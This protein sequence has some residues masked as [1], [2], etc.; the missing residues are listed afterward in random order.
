MASASCPSNSQYEALVSAQV[1]GE[2]LIPV[3]QGPPP[4]YS[5]SDVEDP[6]NDHG[7][8]EGGDY[9][10]GVYDA[11]GADE[12]FKDD[13]EA[14][15]QGLDKPYRLA[16]ETPPDHPAYHLSFAKV[17]SICEDLFA[18]AA[19]LLENSDYQDTYTQEL[20]SKIKQRQAIAHDA[21]K[22]IGLLGDSGVGTMPLQLVDVVGSNSI[23]GSTGGACTCVITEYTQAPQTQVPAF[24]ADIE[25]FSMAVIEKILKEH[26][27]AYYE[28]HCDRSVELKGDELEAAEMDATT[29][30]DAFK[31]LFA[32]RAEFRDKE[33]ATKFLSATTSSSDSKMLFKLLSWVKD[34]IS[35][36]GCKDGSIHRSSEFSDNF[37]EHI[38]QFVAM[39]PIL[40]DENGDPLEPTPSFYPIV[41]IVRV[42]LQSV[43]LS[44]GIVIADLPGLS[45]T[46]RMR[47]KMTQQYIRRCAYYVLVAPI[48]RVTTDNM[49]HHRLMQAFL[50]PGSHK[51]L[52]C[53][54]IDHEALIIM[55]NQK[56][57]L[58]IRNKYKDLTPE[59]RKLRVV[60]VS[61]PHYE[62]H[63]EG[64][65]R[66]ALPISIETTG[67]PALR[68]ELSELPAQAKL[69]ALL[70]RV[71]SGLRSTISSLTNY[72]TQSVMHRQKDLKKLVEKSYEMHA[73]SF[74]AWVRRYGAHKT[75]KYGYRD[76]NAELL[77]PIRHDIS[78]VWKVFED[79]MKGCKE[80]SLSA[81]EEM[82]DGVRDN[83]RAEQGIA[84][85]PMS[86]FLA[87][88]TPKKLDLQSALHRFSNKFDSISD[89]VKEK[90]V[91]EDQDSYLM[92]GMT[93]LYEKM[94]NV[95]GIK[96]A[97]EEGLDKLKP[98]LLDDV[99][100]VFKDVSSDFDLMFVVKELP[101][102]R[103][104]ALRQRI[105]VF[106]YSAQKE[107]D[108]PLTQ[109]LAKATKGSS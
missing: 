61:N 13:L 22:R 43:F 54:K 56:I 10:G 62:M 74:A 28:Y 75:K 93:P 101:D 20:Q 9:E 14:Q 16:N 108:G 7:S 59:G 40:E 70:H 60:C 76:W 53:T 100:K 83:L 39:K 79:K 17:E 91:V 57:S 31:A 48:S 107:I 97:L 77:E 73:S 51:M 8:G 2:F 102:S 27:K 11:D 68:R 42:G 24:H 104:D 71:N 12:E 82:V 26:L 35:L 38:E 92:Q 89:K 66:D 69:E 15:V 23:E 99:R 55:R 50:R 33:T 105:K 49:V 72:S 32:D 25:L 88:L 1:S 41:K 106:V 67:I 44:R 94:Q 98:E 84:M 19:E 3:D 81:L 21:A 80:G 29:A 103:R 5:A 52:I 34:L 95:T 36:Y 78:R 87:S 96:G 45:D 18:K 46:N 86:P 30:M 4:A 65:D 6:D 109:E 64:Y 63:F 85:L 58:D 47:V 90:A 37:Y